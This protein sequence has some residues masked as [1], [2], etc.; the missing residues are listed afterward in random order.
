MIGMGLN[1]TIM[2]TATKMF[3]DIVIA[4]LPFEPWG[5]FLSFSQRGLT[6]DNNLEVG[7]FFISTVLQTALRGS[8]SKFMGQKEG[9]R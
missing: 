5:F 9:P 2:W 4:K 6:T 3:S 1:V 7:L 8:V